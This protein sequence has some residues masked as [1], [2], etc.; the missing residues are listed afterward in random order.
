MDSQRDLILQA[1]AMCS[2]VSEGLVEQPPSWDKTTT[3]IPKM[4]K[5]GISRSATQG[6]RGDATGHE[7]TGHLW[8]P[9][10]GQISGQ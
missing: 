5:L 10:L 1:L 9:P 6:D 2:W 8:Q 4:K 3:L 7:E